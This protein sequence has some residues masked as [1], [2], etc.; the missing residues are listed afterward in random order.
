[1]I[2]IPS[3]LTGL[4]AKLI[5]AVLWTV[6]CFSAGFYTKGQFVKA[7][8]VDQMAETRKGDAHEVQQSQETDR[9]IQLR[10]DASSAHVDGVREIVRKRAATAA[11][12]AAKRKPDVPKSSGDTQPDSEP[13]TVVG[14]GLRAPRRAFCGPDHLATGDIRLFNLAADGRPVDSS[15]SLDAESEADSQVTGADFCDHY[16]VVVKQY[17]ELAINHNA[18]VDWVEQKQVEQHKRLKAF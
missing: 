16:L 11:K 12:H 8:K 5:A 10:T 9:G 6:I 7:D 17:N 1:M 2:P 4:A 13:H 15:F 18:L 14:E 3:W